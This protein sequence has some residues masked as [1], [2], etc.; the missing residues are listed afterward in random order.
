MGSYSA[1]GPGC[2]SIYRHRMVQEA[3]GMKI[4]QKRTTRRG[5]VKVD[6]LDTL[7]SKLVRSLAGWKCEL[8]GKSGETGQ[9]HCHHFIGRR[10]RRTRWLTENAIAACVACHNQLEDFPLLS[11]DVFVKRVG[12][13]RA[14]QLGML[15]RSGAK[16][17]DRDKVE[18]ELK[19]KL[20]FLGR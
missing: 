12:S 3:L 2:G 18:Q 9:L 11:R 19:E 15:A 20:A 16:G 4:G 17:L 8:C 6:K 5:G 10:Y 1:A 7:F 13:D 14:E